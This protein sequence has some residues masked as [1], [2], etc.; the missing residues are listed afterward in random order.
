MV[1]KN[2]PTT[3]GTHTPFWYII[4]MWFL[5]GEKKFVFLF[6]KTSKYI[7]IVLSMLMIFYPIYNIFYL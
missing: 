5:D 7:M 4:K 3:R 1:G 2:L 6:I